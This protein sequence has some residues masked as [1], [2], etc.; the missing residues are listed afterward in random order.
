MNSNIVGKFYDEVI[1]ELCYPEIADVSVDDYIAKSF[2]GNKPK[3]LQHPFVVCAK[4]EVTLKVESWLGNVVVWTF[5]AGVPYPMPLRKIFN[6]AG[7]TKT[8][9]QISY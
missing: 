1:L 2:R 8:S 4:E 6:D 3:E 5:P 7:N 9:I